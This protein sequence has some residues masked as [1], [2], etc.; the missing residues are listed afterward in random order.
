MEQSK[1]TL[2]TQDVEEENK[3]I[4]ESDEVSTKEVIK[5]LIFIVFG[6][7]ISVVCIAVGLSLGVFAK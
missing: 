5:Y 7:I 3:R 2:Y 6:I 4:D 1:D